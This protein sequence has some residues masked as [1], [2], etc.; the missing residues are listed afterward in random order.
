MSVQGKSKKR[1]IKA[2]AIPSA[3]KSRPK[4]K[5][6]QAGSR[7]GSRG[8]MKASSARASTHFPKRHEVLF[9]PERKA[10]VRSV[11]SKEAV[12]ACVFC[13]A[14]DSGP[15]FDSLLVYRNEHAMV[16]LNKFPYN[17][18][19]VLILPTRHMGDLLQ[20]TEAE[21]H[22]I[23]ALL[24]KSV[25][26]LKDMYTPSGFNIGINLGAAAGA[27]IPQ[28]LHWHVVPRWSGDTNFFP[29]IGGTKVVVETL[30]LTYQ[31]LLPYFSA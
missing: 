2:S 10:Y 7:S 24:T 16:V 3:K 6:S 29:L 26:A 27:G 17:N 8:K 30:E 11:Q 20:L 1:P 18:G 25:A 19:H 23:Q 21:S 14:R 9:K 4:S 13:A 31:R 28:H 12:G 15:S 5:S 22:A